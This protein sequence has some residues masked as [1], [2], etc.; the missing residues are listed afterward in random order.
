MA[1]LPLAVIWPR[2]GALPLAALAGL[3][4]WNR[5][6]YL[7]FLRRGGPWFALACVP[8]HL[9]YYVYSGLSYLYAWL[10]HR[11]G[12]Q[13]PARHRH[14][15]RTVVVIGGGP[16][17]LTAAYE[18]SKFN[19][20]PIVLRAQPIVGGLASTQ[21]YKGF[22]STWAGHRFFT[23]A[24]EVRKM[25]DEVLGGEFLLRPRLSRIYYNGKF[26]YYPLRP[27]NALRGLG[28]GQSLLVLMSYLWW[29][30]FPSRQENTFAE[31]V[32]NRFGRRLFRTFFETYTEKVWGSRA[33]SS[34]P[35]GPLSA[36]RTCPSSRR[37]SACS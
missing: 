14:A 5:E 19:L 17:G 4:V 24:E 20:R 32:T 10:A 11:F 6:L 7:F 3:L 26:F 18:L 33:R 13:P 12:G 27:F 29:Q 2:L 21:T 37:C 8:L 25:W 36:S 1:S 31:W 34:K 9:L 15:D 22:S 16:A 28:L 23:K 30:L 35:S